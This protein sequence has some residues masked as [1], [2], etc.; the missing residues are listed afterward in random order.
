M[1]TCVG[2]ITRRQTIMGGFS[3]AFSPF[4]VASEDDDDDFDG[5]DADEDDSASSPSDDEMST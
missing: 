4:P 1:N 2:R 5:D 3:V